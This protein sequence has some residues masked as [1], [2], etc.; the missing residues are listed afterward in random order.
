MDNI[1]NLNQQDYDEYEVNI[2]IR[3]KKPINFNP[4]FPVYDYT[5]PCDC[6]SNNPKNN[7]HASGICHCTNPSM[8]G[9]NRI[10]F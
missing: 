6:C 9:P 10:S 8:Y 1:F 3:R 5:N 4:Q 7:P 2:K